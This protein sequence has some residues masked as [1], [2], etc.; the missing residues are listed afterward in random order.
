MMQQL[1]FDAIATTSAGLAWSI[2]RPQYE[3]AFDDVIEHLAS[4]CDK[5]DLP[6]T[7]D[8]ESGFASDPEGLSV[9]VDVIVDTGIAGFSIEDRDTEMRNRLYEMSHAAERVAAAREAIDHFDE[10]VVLVAQTMELLIDPTGVKQATA[11][12]V[13]FAEAGADC[14]YAPGVKTK[15]DIASMVQAVAPKPLC[16]LIMESGL[17]VAELAELGVRRIGVG[18]ALAQIT[19]DALITAARHMR[20]SSFDGLGSTTS[21]PEL[22]SSFGKFL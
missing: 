5:V 9:N 7:A 13:A 15:Q 1:G 6:V 22:N 21:G 19:W 8:F 10:N 12:L 3:I 18:S 17:T 16:V 2:G 14:L 11:R 4:L 20:M